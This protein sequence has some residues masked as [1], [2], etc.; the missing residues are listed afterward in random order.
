MG[1]LKFCSLK[2]WTGLSSQTLYNCT[3]RVV[4]KNL[5]LYEKPVPQGFVV[6][7]PATSQLLTNMAEME[8]I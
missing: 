7:Q 6:M 4:M 1:A 2:T 3:E 5:N 8:H